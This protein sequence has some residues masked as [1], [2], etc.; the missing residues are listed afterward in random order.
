MVYL[1][2]PVI[3]RGFFNRERVKSRRSLEGGR[4]DPLCA[5]LHSSG[6]TSIPLVRRYY[7]DIVEVLSC[8]NIE[9]AQ[10]INLET[11]VIATIITKNFAI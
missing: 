1:G 3:Q 8:K 7:P 4:R 5:S 2:F 11:G 10:I 9:N 6:V